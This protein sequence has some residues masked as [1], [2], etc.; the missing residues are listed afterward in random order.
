VTHGAAVVG[1]GAI[2][3]V[4][5][6]AI[7]ESP[8]VELVGVYDRD[9]VRARERTREHGASRVLGSWA[10]VLDGRNSVEIILAAC[11]VAEDDLPVHLPL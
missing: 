8:G 2:A 5:S 1:R 10:E 3:H 4:H 6:H 11:R 9:T 7:R